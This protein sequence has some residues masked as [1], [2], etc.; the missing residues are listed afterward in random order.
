MVLDRREMMIGGAGLG[1]GL[2]AVAGPR[3]ALA[4]GGAGNDGSLSAV[5]FGVRP[6]AK[7]NQT[8]ALQKAIDTAA[9]SSAILHI[10][11]GIYLVD[12]LTLES[13]CIIS[14]VPGRSVLKLQGDSNLLV[15]KSAQN[16]HLSGLVLEGNSARGR[17]E[18]ENALLEA[19][20]IEGL[21]VNSCK[22]LSSDA[23][24]ISLN[25]CS[26]QISDNEIT[27]TY[28]TGLFCNDSHGL[29]ISHN[30]VHDCGNNGIQIWRSSPGEDGT[31]VAH[32][33]ID[34]IRAEAGGSG[35]NGNGIN[36]FR[37]NDVQVTGNRITDCAFSAIRGNAASNFQII[38]NSCSRL[39]EVALYA[40]F[41]FEGVV[42]T[43]N[44][45]DK[46]AMGISVTNFN[47]GGR[48]AVIQGNLIRNLFLLKRDRGVGIAVEA[49]SM[50]SGNVIEG[51]PAAGIQIGWGK[52][53]RDVSVTGNLVR[54]ARIGIGVS[55]APDAGY[56]FITNNM[57]SKTKEGGIRAMDHD[58]P[59]GPDLAKSSAESYRNIAV[60]GNVSL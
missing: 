42:I 36:V 1:A 34:N 17:S 53:L 57:I 40:E 38:S 32:N 58:K 29:D 3:V 11:G 2:A 54:E 21:V 12:T 23:N 13:N 19:D 31:I 48:M 5:D 33:R 41:G 43:N 56:A 52:H 20:K 18:I 51:A 47:E 28:Q 50:V 4:K 25:K 27:K 30:H 6:N 10:P 37:A 46:A 24:G 26:G 49:D 8:K 44:L 15:A 39:G 59:L 7:S 60:F 14:G 35:E 45:V 22:F 9:R 55:S 16:I